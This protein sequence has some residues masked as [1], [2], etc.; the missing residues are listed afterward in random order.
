MN[1]FTVI[2]AVALVAT[3]AFASKARLGALQASPHLQ[4]T[5]DVFAEPDQAM[6][7]GEFATIE[8]S[9]NTS[10]ANDT[11]PNAEGG[12]VRKMGENGALGAYVGNKTGLATDSLALVGSSPKLQNPLN[13]YYASKMGD[14]T[15]GLGLN[16]SAAE[17]KVAKSK[18]SS[19]G[20]NASVNSAAG[21]EA[22]LA[23]GL[24]G[25]ATLADTT[26]FEQKTPLTLAG[27]YWMDTGRP[28]QLLEVSMALQAG[29]MQSCLDI[30][31]I[32]KGTT[33]APSAKVTS[34]IVGKDCA[35]GEN[36]LLTCCLLMDDVLV[37]ANC[38]LTGVILDDGVVVEDGVVIQGS[39]DN[40]RVIAAG[41]RIG[42]G[43]KL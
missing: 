18:S 3:S 29:K 35:I 10:G 27:G 43:S 42:R 32:A 38:Q 9:G 12:F 8:L 39:I 5:R 33:I 17:D 24:T 41:S 6:V 36:S 40:V 21:W 26:K 22:N 11:S 31:P 20:L 4:D 16:Y 34:T 15:W 28:E 13:V 23:L 30:V 37:G 1:K 19:M 25:E 7:H 2:V 14:M